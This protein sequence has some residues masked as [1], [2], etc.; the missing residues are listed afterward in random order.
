[1]ELLWVIQSEK[2]NIFFGADSGYGNH[3]KAIG[4]KYGPF[5]FAMIGCGQYHEFCVTLIIMGRVLS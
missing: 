4:E 3:F 5:E 1:L 2:E